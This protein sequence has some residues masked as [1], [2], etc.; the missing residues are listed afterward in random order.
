M[1]SYSRA[2]KV[3]ATIQKYLA[4]ILQK[5][6]RDPRLDNI[7]ISRVKAASDIK[8]ARVYYAVLANQGMI[9]DA[10]K[11]FESA[12]GYIKRVLAARLGLRYMPDLKYFYDESYDY[13]ERIEHIFRTLRQH[14]EDHPLSEDQ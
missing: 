12:S 13:G 4:E 9:A 5:E 3:G 8:S 14:G 6:I 2:D 1:K 10:A 11:G 7:V